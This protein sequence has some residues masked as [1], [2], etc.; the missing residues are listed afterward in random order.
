MTS[1][2]PPPR[3]QDRADIDGLTRW[4]V[5]PSAT[6][7]V[8]LLVGG[9]AID[10]GVRHPPGLLSLVA[11]AGLAVA[12]LRGGWIRGARARGFLA[13]SFVPAGLM[14]VRAAPWLILLDLG[15]VAGLLLLA[16]TVR[17]GPRSTAR[18]VGRL[19]R[20]GP[21]LEPAVMSVPLVAASMRA[22][23]A[24]SDAIGRRLLRFLR[25]LALA[26]PVAVA[27]AALLAAADAVFRSWLDVPFD[28]GTAVEHGIVIA[29]GCAVTAVLAGHG[30]WA[31]TAPPRVGR[32]LVGPT[33]AS[34][35][36]AGVVAVY[37]TFV[38]TQIIAIAGGAEYVERT[39]ALSYA[40]Y[41]RAGFFQLVAAAVLTLAVLLL[42]RR[43]RRPAG[44]QPARRL[45]TLELCTVGLTLVTVAVAVRRLFLY[46]AAFGLTILRFSTI[47]FAGFIGFVFVVAGLSIA[48]RLRHDPVAVVLVGALV[49]LVAV[50]LANPER[51]IA[52]R[53]IARFG[54][55]ERL[56]VDYL[57]D[58]LGADAV[59]TMLT[60]AAVAAR[61]CTAGGEFDDR[62][63][64]FNWGRVRAA[65]AW[66]D[67]CGSG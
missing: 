56:D 61:L 28:P 32:R 15:A 33:E 19:T 52:E 51:I 11:V 64:V 66:D 22:T 25:G 40:E 24:G 21:A 27:L 31:G 5:A 30:A 60:D 36:L 10:L 2:L 46:E 34:V 45:V 58:R 39:T 18:A 57:V 63:V 7:V 47:V 44:A 8:S 12:G 3:A 20:P 62:T 1:T 14:T 38:A 65:D 26:L 35:V 43:H 23:R 41:A 4:R 67:T 42:L 37:T 13:M 29:M 17:P 55:T 59:P 54:G 6:L 9:A 49:T 53:N 50:N 16:V 48:G